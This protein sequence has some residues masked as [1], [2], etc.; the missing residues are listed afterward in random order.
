MIPA[1]NTALYVAGACVLS[2]AFVAIGVRAVSPPPAPSPADSSSM[3]KFSGLGGKHGPGGAPRGLP[4][5]TLPSGG[6]YRI[7]GAAPMVISGKTGI[8]VRFSGSGLDTAKKE[9]AALDILGRMHKDAEQAGA[10]L[11][12]FSYGTG[13]LSPDE[14]VDPEQSI[15]FLRGSDGSWERMNAPAAEPALSLNLP[16]LMVPPVPSAPAPKA[17]SPR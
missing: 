13:P 1:S 7:E 16:S 8:L 4:S 5:A 6:S 15:V 17:K 14:N 3:V 10:E 2:I 12:I 11:M 9:E